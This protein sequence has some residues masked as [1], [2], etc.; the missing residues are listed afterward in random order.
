MLTVD[1]A[2]LQLVVLSDA[3]H[4]KTDAALQARDMKKIPEFKNEEAERR[5]WATADSTH[6]VDWSLAKRGCF[7]N[8]SRR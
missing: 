5:F 3:Q 2:E 1:V 7:L 4:S 8:S 6:Y